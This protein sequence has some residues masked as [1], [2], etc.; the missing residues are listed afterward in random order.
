VRAVVLT[1][2]RPTLRLEEVADPVAA[3]DEVV[4]TVDACGIC[5]SDLH[6]AGQI[7]APGTILGHEI[8]GTVAEVGPDVDG[9]WT[10]GAPVVARPFIGCFDC[11][12][13]R[14]GRPDHCERFA[15]IGLERPGGFA[16]RVAVSSHELFHAPAALT[17]SDRALVEPLAIARRALRRAGLEPGEDVLVLGGG[18]IGLAVILWA[19]ALGAGS[20]AVS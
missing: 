4:L 6:V 3:G 8:A 17:G 12:W 11:R 19:R 14:S 20:I 18:P 5:G 9:R 13:C 1:E 7:G 2:D 10:V 16:E 15:F